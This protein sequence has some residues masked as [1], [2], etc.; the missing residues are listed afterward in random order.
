MGWGCCTTVNASFETR[1]EAGALLR[2]RRN[3][4]GIEN[5]LLKGCHHAIAASW[6]GS[7]KCTLSWVTVTSSTVTS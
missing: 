2:M 1:A 5:D 7:L 4:Y 6:R 3:F